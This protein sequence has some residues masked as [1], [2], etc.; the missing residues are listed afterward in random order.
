MGG[1]TDRDVVLALRPFVRATGPVLA[2]VRDVDLLGLRE[3]EIGSGADRRAV[4]RLWDQL[5]AFR[6]PGTAAWAAMG[7]EQRDDWW[8]DRLGRLLALLAAV[9]GVGGALADR[10]P[11]QSS[12]GAAGQGLLLAAFAGERGVDS[13][14]DR[15]RLI[16]HVLFQR[17]VDGRL[18]D[19]A[20]RAEEDRR[21]AELTEELTDAL[22]AADAADARN[23]TST[24]GTAGTTTTPPTTTGAKPAGAAPEAADAGP[25]A[26]EAGSGSAAAGSRAAGPE[27]TGPGSAGAARPGIGQRA[28]E[29][30][31]A[32]VKVVGRAVWKLARVL[33]SLE[34][35][36]DKRPQGRVHH[37]V[38]GMLPLVGA[39]GDYFGERHGGKRVRREALAW[40]AAEAARKAAQDDGRQ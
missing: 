37:Q 14:E 19:P 40:F 26:A 34:G 17:E 29:G 28:A 24:G 25:E 11:I 12:L 20:D 10:L 4:D 32:G 23:A 33:W 18:T 3:R 31:K 22:R 9:P 1:I 13:V 8:A 5:A 30:A 2:A 39:V 16:A 15:V 7:V 36:L 21:T 38:I 6:V 35:E 27:A